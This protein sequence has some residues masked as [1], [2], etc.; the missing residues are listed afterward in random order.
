MMVYIILPSN[1]QITCRPIEMRE[2]P[3]FIDY[4]RIR[5]FVHRVVTGK[6]FDAIIAAIIGFNVITMSL[7]YYEMPMVRSVIYNRKNPKFTPI[8]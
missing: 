5:M 1:G 2:P 4:G 6:Y 7:E 3:Y 8:N